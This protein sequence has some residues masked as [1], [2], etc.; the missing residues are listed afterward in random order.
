MIIDHF[1]IHDNSYIPFVVLPNEKKKYINMFRLIVVLFQCLCFLLL[2]CGPQPLPPFRELVWNNT[3]IQTVVRATAS[4][5]ESYLWESRFNSLQHFLINEESIDFNSGYKSEQESSCVSA[6]KSQL[7]T[8][9]RSG[10]LLDPR[11]FY[12]NFQISPVTF[13]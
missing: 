10:S 3:I 12:E 8:S 7:E 4:L 6:F 1:M 2:C 11:R 9:C 5:S 13:A